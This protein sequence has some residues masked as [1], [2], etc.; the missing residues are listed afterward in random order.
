MKT[1]SSKDTS[2][3]KSTFAKV[4]PVCNRGFVTEKEKQIVCSISCRQILAGRSSNKNRK[5]GV[6]VCLQ[7]KKTYEVHSLHQKYCSYSCLHKSSYQRNI[8]THRARDRKRSKRLTIGLNIKN[9]HEQIKTRRA[10]WLWDGIG[11]WSQKYPDIDNC[12]ECN[13]HVYRHSGNGVCEY[14][15]NKLR[16]RDEEAVKK[17]K[18]EWYQKARARGHIF[19]KQVSESYI[20][21]AEH[22]QIPIT[23]VINN[24]L[25]NLHQLEKKP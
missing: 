8:E 25:D 22:K 3:Q 14:C 21:Q 18:E 5:Y 2:A 6:R 23:P 20:Y 24:L 9:E 16:S 17:I 12:L 13:T 11:I 10:R 19:S 15:W 7:C 4:C 1:K